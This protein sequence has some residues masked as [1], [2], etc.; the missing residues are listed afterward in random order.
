MHDSISSSIFD[1]PRCFFGMTF[2]HYLIREVSILFLIG[3]NL[4]SVDKIY[5]IGFG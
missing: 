2:F 5:S 4:L 1:D 3:F